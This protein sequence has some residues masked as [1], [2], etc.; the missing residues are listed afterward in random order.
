[1]VEKIPYFILENVKGLASHNN[2][3]TL[4]VILSALSEAGNY[5][6]YKILNSEN[7][8]VP[9]FRERIYFIGIKKELIKRI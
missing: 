4:R 1:M 9:Q 3:E 5:V 6:D 8:G 2:G 7:Y